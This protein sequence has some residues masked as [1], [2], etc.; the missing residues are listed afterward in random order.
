MTI[1]TNL[2]PSIP[3]NSFAR[4]NSLHNAWTRTINRV[5]MVACCLCALL[6]ITALFLIFGYILFRGVSSINLAFF[7]RLPAP[8]DAVGGMRNGI[9]GTLV[10]I[11]MASVIGVPVGMLCG[12]YLAEY[13]REN[14]FSHSLRLVVDVLAGVPSIIV[15]V[16][17]YMMLVKGW[18]PLT[19]SDSSVLNP[20]IS[21]CNS[22]V[23]VRNTLFPSHASAWAGAVALGFMMCPIIARTTEEMLKLVPKALREASIGMGASKTQTLTRVV[24]P[25]AASGIITGVMLAVARVAGETAPLLFTVLGYDQSIVSFNSSFPFVHVALSDRFPSLTLQI[26]KYATSAENE[27]INEAW[28]GMVVL[29]VI[30]LVLNLAVRYV[31]RDRLG[32]AH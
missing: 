24:L 1:E 6:T 5:A 28:A 13:A 3:P 11:S 32:P 12:I 15:G 14:W 16:L 26:F 31:S 4:A 2:L 23:W 29:I 7:T 19:Y 25:A 18:T 30:I 8:S 27:W 10:L 9:A 17:G 21:L 22:V 20:L